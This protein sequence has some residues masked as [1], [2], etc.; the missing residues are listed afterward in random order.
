MLQGEK[1]KAKQ[2]KKKVTAAPVAFFVKL[3]CNATSEEE[4]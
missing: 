3:R 1:K 2:K 4:E